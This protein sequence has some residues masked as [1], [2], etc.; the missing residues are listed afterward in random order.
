MQNVSQEA[1]WYGAGLW[2]QSTWI[3]V[4]PEAVATED[5]VPHAEVRAVWRLST[6]IADLESASLHTWEEKQSGLTRAA[7]L[8]PWVT[9]SL[10]VA[11]QL[12]LYIHNY[13]L[14][15]IAVEKPRSLRSDN[16]NYMVE[17]HHIRKVYRRVS[18]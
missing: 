15:C 2:S 4:F 18:A 13:T 11:Y 16:N 1:W 17:G 12:S 14:Q 6:L 9:T 5:S 10:G 8:S 3:K 7:V